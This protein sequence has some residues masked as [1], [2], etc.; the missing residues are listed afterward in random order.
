MALTF[1][2]SLIGPTTDPE[3]F[4]ADSLGVIFPGDVTNLHGDAEHQIAYTSP[5]LRKPL[6][7]D[8]VAPID[9]NER[10]LFSHYMWNA[11]LQLGEFIEAACLGLD[12]V[13]ISLGPPIP[14]FDVKGLTTLEFGAGT[15]LPSI[16]SALLGAQRVAVTDYPT[17]SVLATLR[18]NITRNVDASISPTD[19]IMAKEVSVEGHIWGKLD[20][21]FSVANRHAFDRIFLAD[22][23]WMPWEHTNLY[24]S[25]DWFLRDSPGA[26]CWIVSGF[27]TGRAKMRGFFEKTALDENGFEVESIWERDCDGKEREWAWDRGS[28]DITS[29]KRWLACCILK[30]KK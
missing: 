27:H 17:P 5:H 7:F 25:I 28:E 30:R 26:R 18:T 20:D 1:R 29:G 22:C 6:T 9:E 14:D 8:L 19:K 4:I 13:E 16:M 3:D 11:S 2:I 23:L 10:K 12:S 21:A 24:K 15:A